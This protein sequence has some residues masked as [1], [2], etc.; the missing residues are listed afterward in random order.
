MFTAIL[1]GITAK[2]LVVQHDFVTVDLADVAA[3][4][5]LLHLRC[6]NFYLCHKKLNEAVAKLT[7]THL[8]AC[9]CVCVCLFIYTALHMFSHIHA[10]TQRHPTPTTAVAPN[11]HATKAAKN[12]D[13]VNLTAIC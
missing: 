5:C 12:S 1:L 10:H 4:A 6:W 11:L 3:A 8:C 7:C 2:L 13:H 9:V